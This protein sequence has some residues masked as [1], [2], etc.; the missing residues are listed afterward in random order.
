M[1]FQYP[2]FKALSFD[3]LLI[4][5]LGYTLIGIKYNAINEHLNRS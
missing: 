5:G 1:K 3:C 4:N 2:K